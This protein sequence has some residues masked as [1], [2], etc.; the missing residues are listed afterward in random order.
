M[1]TYEKSDPK[2][3]Q[4]LF[5]SI[6]KRYDV[7][8][9]ILSFQLHRLW[10]SRLV[11]EMRKEKNPEILLDLCAGTGDIA[12]N[13][14]KKSCSPSKA[15]LLDFC[16]QML[17]CAKE[18]MASNRIEKHHTIDFIQGDAQEL[19]LPKCSVD[20][21]TIAYGIRNV[22]EPARC[23]AE[24]FRVLKAGGRLGILELTRPQHSFLRFGH[25]MYLKTLLPLMGKL[26]TDNQEAYQYLC[27]SIHHF[28]TPATMLAVIKD[29]GYENA[30]AIPLHGGI[31]TLFIADK[32]NK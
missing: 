11:D 22:K 18:K 30:R 19:P 3:I 1:T 9:S 13:F 6:A 7:T 2:T 20:A 14:L 16:P 29:A 8:N 10:N 25:Q 28:V 4:A 23:V 31:A 5:G 26:I 15:L 12:F 32:P 17:E 24:T 21:V 27:N